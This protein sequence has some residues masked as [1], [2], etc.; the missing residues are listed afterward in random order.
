MKK[1]L[2]AINT[3]NNGG[4]EKVLLT[5]L[6]YLDSKKYEIHLLVVFGEGIYFEQIPQYVRVTH[7][8]PCKSKEATKEIRE[9]A[10]K[11]YEQY[12][13]EKTPR[14][15]LFLN[16]CKAFFLGGLICLLGQVI[17][18]CVPGRA[19]HEDSILLQ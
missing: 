19:V 11:L 12:V 10:A 13:K 4:A 2:F 8:F 3:L 17:Y 7:I 9:H 5:L 1:I 18:R 15:N 16:M 14:H 6:R